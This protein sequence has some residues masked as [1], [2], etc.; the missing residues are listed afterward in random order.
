MGVGV[1]RAIVRVVGVLGREKCTR[2]YAGMWEHDV[3]G[4]ACV[5]QEC[6]VV[7]RRKNVCD[8]WHKR[9]SVA[10]CVKGS[11]CGVKNTHV[12]C[13]RK[14]MCDLC[15]TCGTREGVCRPVYEE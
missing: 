1:P 11:A 13:R 6:R 12:T 14:S 15:V 7:R 5:E 2:K 8:L 4:G 3:G 9:R 10:S